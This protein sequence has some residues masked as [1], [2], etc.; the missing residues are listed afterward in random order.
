MHKASTSIGFGRGIG[1]KSYPNIFFFERLIPILES[2]DMLLWV[3]GTCHNT[4]A[5]SLLYINYWLNFL[6]NLE[7]I[8]SLR[9]DGDC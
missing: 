5:R 7:K 9:H 2:N 1:R 8:L 6:D 3:E 4:K